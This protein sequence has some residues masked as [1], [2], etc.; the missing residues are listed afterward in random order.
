LFD[1]DRYIKN[2]E[3]DAT[4]GTLTL[5]ASTTNSY[6]FPKSRGAANQFLSTDGAGLAR[7]ASPCT[8]GATPPTGTVTNGLLWYNLTNRVM[9][10]AENGLWV[11]I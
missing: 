9:Y 5:N 4:V 8:I 11:S 1:A 2:Y 3:D 7:W 10:V 6:Q